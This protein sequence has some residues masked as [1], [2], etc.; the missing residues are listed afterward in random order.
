MPDGSTNGLSMRHAVRR[1]RRLRVVA[2]DFLE[3]PRPGTGTPEID[4]D[5]SA[6]VPT[7][8]CVLQHAVDGE[9]ERTREVVER[10]EHARSICGSVAHAGEVDGRLARQTPVRSRSDTHGSVTPAGMPVAQ[11][12]P[13]VRVQLRFCN[14]CVARP[15]A[16]SPGFLVMPIELGLQTGGI[17]ARYRL[18]GGDRCTTTAVR[19]K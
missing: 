8:F 13:Q 5:S 4:A 14:R 2:D 10:I 7:P 1:G 18:R 9:Q 16:R 11:L 17:A 12:E 19:S 6:N 15:T 3:H